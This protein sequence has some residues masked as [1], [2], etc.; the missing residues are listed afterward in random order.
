MTTFFWILLILFIINALLLI[1]SAIGSKK[2]SLN[3]GFNGE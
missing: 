1:V 2:G 3:K